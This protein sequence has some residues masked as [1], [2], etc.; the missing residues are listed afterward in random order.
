[1]ET[2]DGSFYPTTFN[3]DWQISKTNHSEE[4]KTFPFL[5]ESSKSIRR[6]FFHYCLTNY[7]EKEHFTPQ[8]LILRM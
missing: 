6:D 3:P 8:L 4:K 1:M 5:V 2:S 7:S